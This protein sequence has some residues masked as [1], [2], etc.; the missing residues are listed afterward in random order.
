MKTELEVNLG[1][2]TISTIDGAFTT[3][4]DI[5]TGEV[6]ELDFVDASINDVARFVSKAKTRYNKFMSSKAIDDFIN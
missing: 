3:T 6:V 2:A 4:I 5:E 1:R